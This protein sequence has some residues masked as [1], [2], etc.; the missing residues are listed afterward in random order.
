MDGEIMENTKIIKAYCKKYKQHFALEIKQE[1]GRWNVVNFTNLSDEEAELIY[2]EI[3]QNQFETNQ[4]LLPCLKCG[5]RVVGGCKCSQKNHP[6]SQDMEYQFDC[7]YCHELTLDYS[8]PSASALKRAGEKVTLP[9]GKEVK[10]VTFS[11]VTWTKFDR[12]QHHPSGRR[13]N[14]PMVHVVTNE[15]DIEFHGYNISEMNEGVYYRI[16]E[17]DDFVIECDVDTSTIKP[18]P[19]GFLYIS[20]GII[21]AHIEQTGGQ[22]FLNN[23]TIA[24]VGSKFHMILSLT[25]GGRYEVI[26]NGKSYCNVFSENKTKVNIVFG[27]THGSHYCKLLS[28][29]YI[30]DIKMQQAVDRK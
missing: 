18:H 15:K 30:R 25:E 6:C 24:Q 29:A 1:N 4:A 23:Q 20:L 27:F 12:I 3:R 22:F 11:N 10:I 5:S 21:S 9:Q 17:Q 28:H 19:G 8:L 16:G 2:S 26:I 7:I 13:F 14:E